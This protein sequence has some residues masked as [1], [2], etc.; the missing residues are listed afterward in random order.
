MAGSPWVQTEK[1]G[2]ATPWPGPFGS[3]GDQPGVHPELSSIAG[4]TEPP[5]N[6][7]GTFSVNPSGAA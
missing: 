3:I 6:A 5:N 4:F 2:G 7:F 1:A